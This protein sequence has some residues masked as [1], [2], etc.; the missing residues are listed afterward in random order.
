MLSTET[1]N[2]LSTIK[3]IPSQT[4]HSSIA[5]YCSTKRESI[6]VFFSVLRSLVRLST[7]HVEDTDTY[8]Y[9]V[10]HYFPNLHK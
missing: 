10:T 1:V 4:E 7:N 5:C 6:F 9:I 8:M 3:N 2:H